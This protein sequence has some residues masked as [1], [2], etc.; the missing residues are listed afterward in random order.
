MNYHYAAVQYTIDGKELAF[1]L[2]ISENE[3]IVSLVK[4]NNYHTIQLCK[5]ANAAGKL[6]SF[7]NDC[8]REKG[9]CAI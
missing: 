6:A 1:V 8:S 5:T 7:W 3:N 2:R 4:R 9:M